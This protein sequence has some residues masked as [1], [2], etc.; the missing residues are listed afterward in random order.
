M[1]S[2][3]PAISGAPIEQKPLSEVERVVDTFVAPS[4]TFTDLRRSANWLVP[5][6]L[7]SI[8]SIA[9][10]VVVDKKLG[11]EKVVENQMALQPKAAARLDQLSPEQR[12]AQLQT[13]VKFNRIISYVY[14]V[15]L[16]IILAII[17]AILMATFNFG[18]GTE[19]TFN[20]C[21]AVSMYASL[22]GILK[23]LIAMLVVGMG[24]GENFTFQNPVASNLGALVD[25]QLSFSLCDR[26]VARRHHDLDTDIDWNRLFLFDQGEAGHLSRRRLRMVGGS[27]SGRSGYRGRILLGSW[28]P[29]LNSASLDKRYGHGRKIK[30]RFC[31]N[32]ELPPGTSAPEGGGSGKVIYT[33]VALIFRVFPR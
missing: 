13:V 16:L 9:L 4:K 19:L 23:A 31:P 1:S 5:F 25:S 20:Q 29:S 24:G 15:L 26:D 28:P 2:T 30:R 14:P 11:M 32:R 22:P 18:F 8:A 21:L 27:G 6:V 33:S 12:A 10:V 17:A 7:L 3:T